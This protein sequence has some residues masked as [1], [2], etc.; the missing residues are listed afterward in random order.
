MTSPSRTTSTP[1]D[2]ALRSNRPNSP[3]GN[4]I[5]I[6]INPNAS[7]RRGTLRR[8]HIFNPT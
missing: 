5:S 7:S 2:A 4:A 1:I 3:V 8:F 6:S